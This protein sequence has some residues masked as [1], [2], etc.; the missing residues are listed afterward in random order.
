MQSYY[1]SWHG[2]FLSWSLTKAAVPLLTG[3][4]QS[5]GNPL[6]AV[7]RPFT[8]LKGRLRRMGVWAGGTM[9]R[10]IYWKRGCQ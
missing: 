10:L 2:L 1:S 3:R 5:R 7:V 6:Q 4:C 8:P 9:R